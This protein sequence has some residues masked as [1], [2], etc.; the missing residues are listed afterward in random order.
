MAG[1]YWWRTD[2]MIAENGGRNPS[3]PGCG[4]A[5]YPTDDHGRFACGCGY[6]NPA[7][8][9]LDRRAAAMMPAIKAMLDRPMTD[10]EKEDFAILMSGDYVMGEDGRPKRA[11]KN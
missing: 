2:R 11:P 4:E 1:D 3:C 7:L 8:R 5:M 9:A 10:E 6:R